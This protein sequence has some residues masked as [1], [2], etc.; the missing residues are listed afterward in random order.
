MYIIFRKDIITGKLV[1]INY[2]KKEVD[3]LTSDV[4]LETYSQANNFTMSLNKGSKT[5]RMIS[6]KE[7]ILAN[8]GLQ[9]KLLGLL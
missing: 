3:K 2:D 7:M 5:Y 1:F 9:D 4:I 6:V 8:K